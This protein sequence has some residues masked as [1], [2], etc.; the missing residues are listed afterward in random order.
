MPGIWLDDDT[1]RQTAGELWSH[2]V[3]Q[4]VQAG[5]T[6]AQQAMHSAMQQTQAAVQQI[7]PQAP[8]A[9]PIAPP[10]P[11]PTPAPAP[12][13][14]VTPALGVGQTPVAEPPP[15]S[16]AAPPAVP[17]PTPEPPATATPSP[18]T[19][20]SPTDLAATGANWA[21]QQIQ[22]LLNPAQ[23]AP[24]SAPQQPSSMPALTQTPS[25]LNASA[26]V[27]STTSTGLSTPAPAPTPTLTPTADV[28]ST[29]ASAGAAGAPAP[30]S[31]P[32]KD[33][34]SNVYNQAAS[35]AAQTGV[36]PRIIATI[37]STETGHEGQAAGHLTLGIGVGAGDNGKGSSGTS[38]GNPTPEGGRQPSGFWAYNDGAEAAQAFKSYIEKWQPSL[39]PLLNDAAKFFD[40]NGPIR[41]SNY[42]VPTQAEAAAQGGADKAT[43]NYYTTWLN[44]A[45]SLGGQAVAT[46]Q[47]VVQK[48]QTAVN[49][50]VEG[51]QAVVARTSQFAMGLS[52]GDAMAFCGPAA[53][54]AFAQTYGRNPT[55]DEAK[56]LAQQVGWSQAGMAGPAS[57]VSLLNKLGIDAHMTNGIDWSA[58]A[59]SASSG[60]PVIINAPD[61]YY[62][63]D[64]YNPK[65]NQFH[66][67]SSATDLKA[68]TAKQEWFTSDQIPGLGQGTPNAAIFADHPLTG[69]S[70]TR[71]GS[72]QQ[73]LT[74]GVNQPVSTPSTPT[75]MANN[76]NDLVSQ[77]LSTGGNAASTLGTGAS[78]L[79]TQGQSA[80]GAVQNKAQ[81]VM[82]AVL[83]VGGPAT[84]ALG[85]AGQTGS[86]LLSGAQD[87]LSSGLADVSNA[88]QSVSNLLQQNALISQ[89]T[90]AVN[91]G[92]LDLTKPIAP[93]LGFDPS[94]IQ[95]ILSPNDDQVLASA[96]P[97]AVDNA[98]TALKLAGI[99]NPTS[100]D[101]ANSVRAGQIGANAGIAGSGVQM[102][103]VLRSLFG[104][105][106]NVGGN[107]IRDAISNPTV[108]EALLKPGE[109]PWSNVSRDL[110]QQGPTNQA[111]S[112]AILRAIDQAAQARAGGLSNP[113]LAVGAFDDLGRRIPPGALENPLTSADLGRASYD[114]YGVFQREPSLYSERG[115][116]MDPATGQ[117]IVPPESGAL[118]WRTPMDSSTVLEGLQQMARERG[119][120]PTAP[121]VS[122]RLQ[123]LAAQVASS[124]GTPMKNFLTGEGSETGSI[125]LG[126]ARALGGGAAGGLGAYETTDPNDPNR[127]LKIAAAAGGGALAGGPGVELA[128]HGSPSGISAADW[129]RGMYRGGLIAAPATML[130]IAGTS[131]VMPVVQTLAG[132]GRDLAT[133]QPGRAVAR[134]QG[135]MTGLREWV[136]TF[137]NALSTAHA[138]PGSLVA[139][140][141]TLPEQ[142]AAYGAEGAGMLHGAFQEATQN[143]IRQQELATGASPAAASGVG[144][145][146]AGGQELGTITGWLGRA[147]TGGGAITDALF[148]IYKKGMQL[149][150]RMVEF[151]P[152]GAAGSAID[153]ARGLAGQGPYAAGLGST[154]TSN[155]VG[156]LS[157]RLVNN[158][159]GTGLSILLA[160][161]ALEG[162]I[163][164]S[165]EGLTPAQQDTLR[166]QGQ[167]PDGFQAGGAWHSWDKLPPALR[168]PFMAAG[169]Y[170]DAQHAYD[171]AQSKRGSS[172]AQAYGVEDPREA[173]AVA[174]MREVSG[175]LVRQTPLKTF[176][177]TYDALT[178]GGGAGA[179][180]NAPV[181]MI[182]NVLGGLVPESAIVRTAAQ[183]G[184][185]NQRRVLQPK[186]LD[187]VLPAILQNVQ[188]NIPGVR[189]QLPTRLDVLGRDVA[190]PQQGLASVL[191]MRAAAGQPSP[192]LAAMGG[193]GVAP[194]SA[195][196]SIP[197]GPNAQ[198]NLRPEEQQTYDRYRG[199]LI[200]QMSN[201]LVNSADF[202][203]M[204]DY[205]QRIAL[206]RVVQTAGEVAG[207]MLLGDLAPQA[208]NR[209]ST[210][211]VLAPVMPY[212]PSALD[213]ESLI[214]NQ[215]SHRALIQALLAQQS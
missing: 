134:M 35:V 61:H 51:V 52:S 58:V 119:I 210:T 19:T 191:P 209:L 178:G 33:W 171:M 166:A 21:Q 66:L 28:Q 158:A 193:A 141:G 87:L 113:Q 117:E 25:G 203:T 104:G 71:S 64:G 150:S 62:Y 194:S 214:R 100:A 50:A 121:M 13:P 163:T 53:A 108:A 172:G 5:E 30:S 70:P 182:S 146:A 130:D 127:A 16:P 22:N 120:D 157:E 148:P 175:Q 137:L 59:Q 47:D 32:G 161:Q 29:P 110:L 54:M 14:P 145:R 3:T 69:S 42:Y 27:P 122:Q 124:F 48:G 160:H 94:G 201:D 23:N 78:S 93:Q 31:L 147:A 202:K 200:Q 40:P 46:A 1:Y 185:P 8:S 7:M 20:P 156:P 89:G 63:V 118:D 79:L 10:P 174:L 180:Y 26:A 65:T 9:Q 144:A 91:V 86:N 76:S 169:A 207:R 56:Q 190:N 67:G 132:L 128:L 4:R 187:E 74:M 183:A 88:P 36:D 39:A 204:P 75:S 123:D 115:I 37:A 114:Q 15:T 55:V 162:N 73:S 43:T 181:D 159:I 84:Q 98:R 2:Q 45:Q 38:W 153:I 24:Q 168:G 213:Q 81:D 198:I 208:Q 186:T 136:P 165:W 138:N 205:A 92:G 212:G 111:A 142:V 199:Q 179:L 34:L 12:T 176:S 155:A 80:L 57:E 82:S 143:L 211:G 77:L 151:S 103:G 125:N 195:P 109:V 140:A 192:I 85:Q 99:A 49:S 18:T 112:P 11:T 6:W 154:P 102:P 152:L 173:A 129:A 41:G 116:A 206:Q 196:S 126:L 139:R 97:Q 90:P 149:A 215:A 96:S 135:T 95:S 188:Q 177:S 44:K 164:G 184:D 68:N 60:N 106:G 170:A 105:E 72:G 197:Y 17:Q 133:L 101:L 189:E 167:M 83:N 107:L 131:A